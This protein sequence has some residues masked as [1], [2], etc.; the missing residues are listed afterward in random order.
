MSD[1]HQQ[2]LRLLHRDVTPTPQVRLAF[3]SGLDSHLVGT[4]LAD[5]HVA[6]MVCC[7]EGWPA[8]WT[9]VG[10]DHKVWAERVRT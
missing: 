3:L 6:G 7:L 10:R 2:I 8:M 4:V 9:L 5:L 1:A